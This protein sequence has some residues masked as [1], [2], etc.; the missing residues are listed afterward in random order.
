MEIEKFYIQFDNFWAETLFLLLLLPKVIFFFFRL[1][2]FKPYFSPV[3]VFVF[4]FFKSIVVSYCALYI[5]ILIPFMNINVV[6]TIPHPFVVN[7]YS[8]LLVFARCFFFIIIFISYFPYVCLCWIVKLIN[9]ST[10][11]AGFQAY[12]LMQ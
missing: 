2:F 9:K 1:P 10:R 11:R 7:L 8:S 6:T 3:D 4:F 12:T 5:A